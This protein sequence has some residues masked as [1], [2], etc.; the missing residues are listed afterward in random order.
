[1]IQTITIDL[2]LSSRPLVLGIK[3]GPSFLEERLVH[4]VEYSVVD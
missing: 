3:I 1:M 2:L 4:V